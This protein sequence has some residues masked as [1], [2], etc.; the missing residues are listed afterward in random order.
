MIGKKELALI[1]TGKKLVGKYKNS[2]SRF[3]DHDFFVR[4]FLVDEKTG[5]FVKAIEM[6]VNANNWMDCIESADFGNYKVDKI[7]FSASGR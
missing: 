2:F 7:E 3:T 4:I 1:G 5:L 6:V